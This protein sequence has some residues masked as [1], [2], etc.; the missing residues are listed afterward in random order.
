[1][2][3]VISSSW[4]EAGFTDILDHTGWVVNIEQEEVQPIS[5]HEGLTIEAQPRMINR[6]TN[7][8]CRKP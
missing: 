1:M 4:Q 8:D 6:L 2:F 7:L 5:H 3:I